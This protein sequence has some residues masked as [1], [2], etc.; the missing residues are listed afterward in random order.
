MS[1]ISVVLIGSNTLFRQSLHQI[2]DPNQFAI[3]AE[4]RDLASVRALINDGVMPDL[5]V[6]DFSTH[7]EEDFESLRQLREV[8]GDCR[9]VVLANELSLCEMA[10][11][12]KAG[13]DGY[14]VNELSVEAFSLSLL[15]VMKGEKV[16][17][18]HL[19]GKLATNVQDFEGVKLVDAQRNLTD[20]ERQIL[21]C[22]LNGYSNK[23]IARAL[24]ITEGTVKVHLKSLMKKIAA[25]NRTQAALWA[26]N[27]G[28]AGPV[29]NFGAT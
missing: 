15:L 18:G 11:A 1:A 20:R 24:G 10:R 26:R 12:L 23:L 21:Q 16:L 4:G 2:L 29:E 25:S 14:L 19:A 28:I 22:L 6:A 5:V 9:I 7:Q 8:G 27:N 17:P 13:V 3:V